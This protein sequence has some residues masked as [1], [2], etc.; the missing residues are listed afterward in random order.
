MIGT[1]RKFDV[2]I[3]GGGIM[4]SSTAYWLASNADFR[5]SISV[6][7]KDPTYNFSTT[8]RS[9]SCIRLQ[10]STS[11]NIEI[12]KF[13]VQFLHH[14]PDYL[15]VDDEVPDV[16]FRECGYL[17]LATTPEGRD[18]LLQNHATQCRHGITDVAA[19]TPEALSARFP[20][21][22]TE[23]VTGATLGL[24]HEGAFDPYSLLQA[25]KKKARS[26]GVKYLSEEVVGMRHAGRRISEV[27]T[28]VGPIA[29]GTVVNAAGAWARGIAAMA[30]IDLPVFPR[31]RSVFVFT[32][33][34]AIPDLP[35]LIDPEG[36]YV[37]PD[38]RNYVCGMKP[39][40]DRDL[41]SHDFE[42][43]YRWFDDE[44]WPRL[45][46]WVPAFES[47]KMQRAW[48]GHYEYNTFDRNALMGAHPS[49]ENLFFCNGFSG[50]GMQQ[51]PAAGRGISELI[52]HGG[53]RTLDLGAFSIQR[54]V[55][56]RPI[57]EQYVV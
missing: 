56:N 39:P 26:L 23:G 30:D 32:C 25:F 35:L 28:D 27:I 50:H 57:I 46:R 21:M 47:V 43:D 48:T 38:G 15:A 7:E 52:T 19:L 51:S 20:W 53:Y 6:I 55:D 22:N 45:A 9:N 49:I 54:L 42:V 31:P 16:S 18:V 24:K 2:V 29:C 36:F 12:S 40:D 5:G 3:V 10:F 33:P 37:R 1:A 13:G 8:A 14:L 44:L 17:F 41:D 4:G 34:V 11:L